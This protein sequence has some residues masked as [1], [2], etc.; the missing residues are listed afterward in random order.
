MARV[1]CDC[2]TVEILQHNHHRQLSA[3]LVRLRKMKR[4]V[5]L[6]CILILNNNIYKSFLHVT[7]DM[8]DILFGPLHL[9]LIHQLLILT[10]VL[11]VGT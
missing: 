3:C 4:K 11:Q 5:L 2:H 10:D 1:C 8:P 7:C 9:I 6:K